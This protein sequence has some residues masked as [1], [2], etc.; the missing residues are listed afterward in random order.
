MSI[1]KNI[2]FFIA[3]VAAH[4]LLHKDDV[5]DYNK[6][7]STVEHVSYFRAVLNASDP[8]CSESED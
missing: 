8:R 7:E 2:L 3:G 4:A 1:P 5:T 6:D